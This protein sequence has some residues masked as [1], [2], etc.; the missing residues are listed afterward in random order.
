ML[1][2][3]AAGLLLPWVVAG[4][5]KSSPPCKGSQCMPVAGT[6][7]VT[8]VQSAGTTCKSISYG[9]NLQVT[10]VITQNESALTLAF[11]GSP[12]SQTVSGTLDA[13][14]SAIF[15]QNGPVNVVD[16]SGT[17]YPYQDSDNIDLNFTA[18]TAGAVTISGTV[19]DSLSAIMPSPSGTPDA[20]C[21][22]DGSVTGSD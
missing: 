8:L 1:R 2:K 5:G 3:I 10:V 6:Y 15:S 22:L 19:T 4:C 9:G 16:S 7:A 13:N 18:G 21:I 11:T 14:N 17:A 20:S 12:V